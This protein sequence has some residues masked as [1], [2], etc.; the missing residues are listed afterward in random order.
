MVK[1][2]DVAF[3]AGVSPSIVSRFINNDPKLSIREETKKRILSAIDQTGYIINPVVRQNKQPIGSGLIGLIFPNINN[4]VYSEIAR[5]VHDAAFC[6]GYNV[7]LCETKDRPNYSKAHLTKLKNR[8]VDAVLYASAELSDEITQQLNNLN[9]PCVLVNRCYPYSKHSFVGTDNVTGA[10]VAVNYLISLGHKKIAYISGPL[11]VDTATERL[12][13]YRKTLRENNLEHYEG[14]T[15][16][17]DFT[18]LGGQNAIKK[19]LQLPDIPTA[20]FC[21]N[22]EM[23][24][25]AIVE[26]HRRG[27]CVPKDISIIGFNNIWPCECCI[28]PL[29][30][31]SFDYYMLGK[32]AVEMVYN[33][34]QD[35]NELSTQYLLKPELI[36]RE[37]VKQI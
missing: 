15:I 13:G 35:K 18:F 24:L 23:A 37:S 12:N 21:G 34:I 8:N 2:K 5:G 11:H 22:D 26:L 4:V 36:V 7:V 1:L 9:L 16:E 28:P 29:T 6:Y 33:K 32:K 20:V 3:I 25:G 14:Y 17:G 31:I 30:T 10:C 19:I 27:I